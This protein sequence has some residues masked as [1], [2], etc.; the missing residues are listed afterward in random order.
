MP[1]GECLH[2][3]E[4]GTCAIGVG[5]ESPFNAAFEDDSSLVALIILLMIISACLGAALVFSVFL[6]RE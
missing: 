2:D 4:T 1:Q 5:F 3:L 6:R